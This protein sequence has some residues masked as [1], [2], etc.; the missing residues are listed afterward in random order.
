MANFNLVLLALL[1]AAVYSQCPT[2]CS[3]CSSPTQCTSCS[4]R[5][6]LVNG[7]QCAPCPTGCSAC[8]QGSNSRPVCTACTAPAQ[9]DSTAGRCFLCDPSCLTCGSSPTTCTSCRDGKVLTSNNTC[10]API[11][12]NITNCGNCT[13]DLAG[14]LVCERCLQGYFPFKQGCVPCK[15]PCAACNFDRNQVWLAVSAFWDPILRAALNVTVPTPTPGSLPQITN[16][17]D[18]AGMN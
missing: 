13:T 7:T 8:N 6:F 1:L 18:F 5:F 9:L 14:N 11:G 16:N 17:L 12:C 2:G 10:G 4:A 15:F 3:A